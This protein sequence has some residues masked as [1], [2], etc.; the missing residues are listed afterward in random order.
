MADDNG[1]AQAGINAFGR[2]GTGELRYQQPADIHTDATLNGPGQLWIRPGWVKI[3]HTDASLRGRILAQLLL[4]FAQ[5]LADGL[6]IIGNSGHVFLPIGCF[7]ISISRADLDLGRQRQRE[8]ACRPRGKVKPNLGQLGFGG[9]GFLGQPRAASGSSGG[10]SRGK[11]QT[12]ASISTAARAWTAWWS[13]DIQGRRPV[14]P[15]SRMF[16][17]L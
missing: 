13:T 5:A 7:Y 4:Q 16:I 3:I 15:S 9:W 17:V 11:R 14:Q 8:C 1:P 10:R 2:R 6:E 12:K